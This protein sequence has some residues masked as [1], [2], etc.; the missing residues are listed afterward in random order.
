MGEG[1]GMI[2]TPKEAP[3]GLWLLRC[4]VTGGK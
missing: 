1:E 4:E 2:E 3:S